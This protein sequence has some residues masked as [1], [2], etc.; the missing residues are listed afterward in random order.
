MKFRHYRY[1]QEVSYFIEKNVEQ[2]LGSL[3]S[4][5]IITLYLGYPSPFLSPLLESGSF[6]FEAPIVCIFKRFLNTG[7]EL[8]WW[9]SREFIID[10]G[11]LAHFYTSYAD[12]DIPFSP[13]S[14]QNIWNFLLAM[15]IC[16]TYLM[17]SS[18]PLWAGNTAA[19]T[20]STVLH[21]Y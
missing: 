11:L 3:F 5:F 15:L 14:G 2:I 1:T 10:L 12:R 20:H 7:V 21:G 19:N 9:T 4:D 13:L 17:I 18:L 16:S 6:S 8:I